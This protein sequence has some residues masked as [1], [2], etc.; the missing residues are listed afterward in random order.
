ML[1]VLKVESSKLYAN[2]NHVLGLV[3]VKIFVGV[4]L[5][6]R[7]LSLEFVE[8]DFKVSDIVKRLDK[9]RANET[10]NCG[11]STFEVVPSI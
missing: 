3:A 6:G 9:T 11:M 4:H 2:C 10:E 5:F 7:I 8:V 1:L